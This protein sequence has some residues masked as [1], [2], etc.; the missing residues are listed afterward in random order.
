MKKNLSVDLN[1]EEFLTH[2]I[3]VAKYYIGLYPCIL[4]VRV[5]RLIVS[6]LLSVIMNTL[7]WGVSLYP[8]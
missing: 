2:C 8:I 7:Y 5:Y 3:R 1:S 6:I 4:Y